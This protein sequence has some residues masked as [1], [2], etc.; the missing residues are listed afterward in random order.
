MVAAPPADFAQ[1]SLDLQRA[2][3]RPADLWD[4]SQVYRTVG[5]PDLLI[6]AKHGPTLMEVPGIP[7]RGC[8]SRSGCGSPWS[9]GPSRS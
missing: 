4:V 8:W 9:L 3:I 7:A 5:S 1:L 6:N 2:T